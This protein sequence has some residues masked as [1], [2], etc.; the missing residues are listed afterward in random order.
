MAFIH[1]FA[2]N[3]AALLKGLIAVAGLG[4]R[5]VAEVV[6]VKQFPPVS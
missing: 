1:P 4:A 6:G 2:V 3:S 5:E